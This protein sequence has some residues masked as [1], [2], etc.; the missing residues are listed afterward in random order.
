M[1]MCQKVTL[2][3]ALMA[4]SRAMQM[5]EPEIEKPTVDRMHRGLMKDRSC[6]ETDYCSRNRALQASMSTGDAQYQ[7]NFVYRLDVDSI[8][9]A[10]NAITAT[11]HLWNETFSGNKVE[12]YARQLQL[13]MEFF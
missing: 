8:E 12:K 10:D 13:Q 1:R 3:F 7:Y 4:C 5:F 11:I 2:L 9:V 6:T